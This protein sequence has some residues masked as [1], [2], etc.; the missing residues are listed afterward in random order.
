MADLPSNFKPGDWMCPNCNAHNFRSRSQC[1]KC[2]AEGGS[3]GGGRSQ[4]RD[5][6]DNRGYDRRGGRDRYDDRGDRGG[7]FSRDDRGRDYS[8]SPPRGRTPPNFKPG[9][10][11]CDECDAHNF[12]RRDTCMRCSKDRPAG[13]GGGS[14]YGGSRY[15][16]GRD[17]GYSGG[18]SGGFDRPDN[19]KPGDWMCPN[20]NAHNFRSRSQCMKCATSKDEAGGFDDDPRGGGGRNDRGNDRG[21]YGGGRGD[22]PPNFKP[23]D[24]MCDECSFHNFR[25]NTECKRCGA[26]APGEGS[27]R[28]SKRS[29]DYEDNRDNKRKRFNR[30]DDSEEGDDRRR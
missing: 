10:W 17:G 3:G 1:M 24:W 6:D 16:G 7:R 30:D 18:R 15:G 21:S 20:C 29:G 22:L 19:F 2:N 28:G 4:R 8:R 12:S 27:P 14:S 11:M 25:S 13:G 5:Y 9:D 26:S 23:G